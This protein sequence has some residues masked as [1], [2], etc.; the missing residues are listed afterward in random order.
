MVGSDDPCEIIGDVE[1]NLMLM[2][3]YIFFPFVQFGIN[4]TTL[5]K[6]LM[7]TVLGVFSIRWFSA[8]QTPDL[9]PVM[10]L[11]VKSLVASSANSTVLLEVVDK[12][13][14]GCKEGEEGP[15]DITGQW[16]NCTNIPS[17]GCLDTLDNMGLGNV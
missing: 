11:V 15:A 4:F 16:C 1:T 7:T 13:T 9:L 10:S 12:G 14:G 2:N 6:S 3:L 17:H 8:L 5:V